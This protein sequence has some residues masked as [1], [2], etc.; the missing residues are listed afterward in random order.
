VQTTVRRAKRRTTKNESQTARYCEH[1]VRTVA[2]IA[3]VR[4]S[5]D[6]L[7]L[8]CERLR[9]W[10]GW[11]FAHAGCWLLRRWRAE[12]LG[13]RKREEATP[14]QGRWSKVHAARN[15]RR[16][17]QQTG[18]RRAVRLSHVGMHHAWRPRGPAGQ[19]TPRRKSW[20]NPSRRRNKNRTRARGGKRHRTEALRMQDIGISPVSTDH[21]PASF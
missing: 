6:R 10:D 4:S 19:L 12:L 21:D 16:C 11:Q 3:P 1:R 2:C 9:L 14:R 17:R 15:E 7:L 8:F 20:Q 18:G 13:G 5:A